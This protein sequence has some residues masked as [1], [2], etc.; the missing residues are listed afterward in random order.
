MKLK[1][2]FHILFFIYIFL[3]GIFTG[4]L[5]YIFSYRIGKETELN[6]IK[7]IET[8]IIDTIIDISD[9]PPKDFAY[10]HAGGIQNIEL[11]KIKEF[12]IPLYLES[13]KNEKRIKIGELDFKRKRLSNN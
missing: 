5:I 12:K 13:Y 3:G 9:L 8:E 11:K 7:I 2:R 10:P 1:P 6:Y 4:I